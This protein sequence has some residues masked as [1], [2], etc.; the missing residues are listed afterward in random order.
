MHIWPQLTEILEGNLFSDIDPAP[1]IVVSV[2]NG[3]SADPTPPSPIVLS[4]VSLPTLTSSDTEPV[5]YV[6]E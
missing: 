1:D 2:V 4:A 6:F 5:P 3:D